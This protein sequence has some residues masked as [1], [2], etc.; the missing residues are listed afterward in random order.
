MHFKIEI[1]SHERDSFVNGKEE[2]APEKEAGYQGK[3]IL[4]KRVQKRAPSTGSGREAKR[5]LN[6]PIMPSASMRA[7]PYWITRRL[8]TCR[9]DKGQREPFTCRFSSSTHF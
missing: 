2:K 6:F 4:P 8:P 7:A 3:G 5:A 9:A 1:Q